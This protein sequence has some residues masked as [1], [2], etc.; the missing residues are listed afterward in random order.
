LA[1]T[2]NVLT[3][4]GKCLPAWEAFAF[5]APG[6]FQLGPRQNKAAIPKAAFVTKCYMYVSVSPEALTLPALED[7]II[8]ELSLAYFR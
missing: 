6:T 4:I 7:N 8:S 1:N 5:A 3:V 2:D